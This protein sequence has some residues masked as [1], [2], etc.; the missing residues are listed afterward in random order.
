MRRLIAITIALTGVT[1]GQACGSSP[2]GPQSAPAG[3]ATQQ[4]RVPGE[5]IVT[6]SASAD[7][8]VISD[9]YGRFGITEI[10]K[11]SSSVFLLTLKEDPGPA[12]MES[13]RAGSAHIKAVEPN[14]VYR[15]Q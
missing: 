6:L 10:R 5:Y 12:T 9:L 3:A 7:A 2:A 4:S 15:T 8:K 14:Y 13:V 1:V 11:L